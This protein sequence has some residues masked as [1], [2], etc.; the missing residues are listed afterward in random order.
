[1]AKEFTIGSGGDVIAFL[2]AQHLQ[3][4]AQFE[5]VLESRGSSRAQAF[6]E[7]RRLLAVHETA[8]E[9]IVHPAARRSLPNGEAIVTARLKEEN[10]A[11]TALASLEKIDTGAPEFDT[12]IRALQTA[13]IAHAESE[14]R[15]E[16]AKL[17][18]KL[19][20]KQLQM[21]RKA[22]HFAESVAPTHPHPGVESA[23]ANILAGPFVSMIDRA[24]DALTGKA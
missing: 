19:D 3:V 20:P 23:T 14:E 10:Q 11:K 5:R 8:E 13:V 15:E 21:M 17:E 6:Q 24:R 4:K 1:M 9:E 18:H 2:K 7:L 12:Q 22:V 16:F